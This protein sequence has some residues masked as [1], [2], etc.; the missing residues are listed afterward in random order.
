MPKI[1][2]PWIWKTRICSIAFIAGY[3]DAEGSF[4]INQNKARFKIDAYDYYILKPTSKFLSKLKINIKFKKISRK[5]ERIYKNN[6]FWNEDLW[7]LNINEANSLYKF[8]MLIN[9]HLKHKRRILD[10]RGCIK[11]IVDRRK[12]GTI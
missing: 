3:V 10:A 1:V 11:N 7:R 4:G 8:I 6:K 5:G 9:A 2:Y 12:N